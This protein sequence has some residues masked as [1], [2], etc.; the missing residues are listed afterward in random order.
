MTSRR[1]YIAVS[2][3][4]RKFKPAIDETSLRNFA[5]DLAD[6]FASDNERFDREKFLSACGITTHE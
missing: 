5:N 1:D 3:L 4:I 6:Y 2:D